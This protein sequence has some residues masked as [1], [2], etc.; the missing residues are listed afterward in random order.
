MDHQLLLGSS[1]QIHGHCTLSTKAFPLHLISFSDK[2]EYCQ[3]NEKVLSIAFA[4]L[5]L[6]VR[7][8]I[9]ESIRL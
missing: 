6:S 3:R 9:T 4:A 5:Y 7:P 2:V 8:E 1:H